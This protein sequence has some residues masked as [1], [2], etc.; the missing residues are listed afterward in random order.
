MSS[1]N[2]QKKEE[3]RSVR[4]LAGGLSSCTAEALT[5]PIDMAKV[6]IF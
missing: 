2:T 1:K 6:C 4:F 5:L 3:P